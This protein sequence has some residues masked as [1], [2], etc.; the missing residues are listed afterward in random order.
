MCHCSQDT[1]LRDI[2]NLIDKGILCDTGKG[3]RNRNYELII[4]KCP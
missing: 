3:G 1:A 4:S 2:H